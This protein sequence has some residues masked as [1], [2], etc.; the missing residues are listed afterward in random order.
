MK[1]L[2]RIKLESEVIRRLQ[3]LPGTGGKTEP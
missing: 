3:A 1:R 2:R